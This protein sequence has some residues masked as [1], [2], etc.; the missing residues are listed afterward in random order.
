MKHP[1]RNIASI[2][3]A[4]ALFALVNDAAPVLAA[5]NYRLIKTANDSKIF[6]VKDNRRIHIPNPS[7][8]E[9][10]GYR[11]SDVKTVSQKEM[12]K[13]PNTGLIKSP[14]DAK[15]YLIKDGTKQWIPDEDAFSAAGLQSKDIVLISQAQV[16]FYSTTDF[17]PEN[18]KAVARPAN[19]VAPTVSKEKSAPS[20]PVSAPYVRP[21]RATILDLGVYPENFAWAGDVDENGNV[22]YSRVTASETIVHSDG[23]TQRVD[24]ITP[25][26]LKNGAHESISGFVETV[27]TNKNGDIIGLVL[28]ENNNHAAVRKNGRDVRLGSLGG[29]YTYPKDINDAGQIVGNADAVAGGGLDGVPEHGFIWENGKMRD[30]GTLG[31]NS[32]LATAIN[33]V[34]QVVGN[35]QKKDGTYNTYPFVWKNGVM[36]EL[37]GGFAWVYDINDSGHAVGHDRS[38]AYEWKN[39]TRATLA[40]FPGTDAA[41]AKAVNNA[42]EIA[43]NISIPPDG[44]ES[45][46]LKRYNCIG[47]LK[48]ESRAVVWQNGEPTFLDDL[49]PKDSGYQLQTAVA[50]NNRG[51]VIVRGFNESKDE[52]RLFLVALP[53]DLRGNKYTE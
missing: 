32:S 39:G 41:E 16:D 28:S 19:P 21:E 24:T 25:F 18:A 15:V 26:I 34:G 20:E 13:I 6:L 29:D 49:F 12:D 44:T 51:E 1:A 42:G 33:N 11:W 30:L 10:G 22:L 2:I 35:A 37:P 45:L 17:T 14:V 4:I 7:V 38:Y 46:Y 27:G 36:T 50:I 8:F 43:G 47:C 52:Y 48:Y 40:E 53:K 23:G 9:A 3:I 31:G 5:K